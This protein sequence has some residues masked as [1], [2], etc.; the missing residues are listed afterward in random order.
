[1]EREPTLPT[2]DVVVEAVGQETYRYVYD[3]TAHAV[4]LAG[5]VS[6]EEDW[7]TDLGT[8]PDTLGPDGQPVPVL[9]LGSHPTFPGCR[10]AALPIGLLETGAAEERRV[11]VLAVPAADPA[12]AALA[13]DGG[14]PSAVRTALESAIRDTLGLAGSGLPRWGD[15]A[16]AIALVREARRA[17]RLAAATRS[18]AAA[19]QWEVR[20]RRLRRAT[21]GEAERHTEAEYAVYALP[22]RFQEYARDCLLPSERLLCYVQR[23]PV[24]HRGVWGRLRQPAAHAGL[25]AVTD[26]QV[27]LLADA[28]PPGHDLIYWGYIARAAAVERLLDAAV[29]REGQLVWLEIALATSAGPGQFRVEFA[30]E[31]AAQ[32]EEVA[33]LLRR[34]SPAVNA[35]RPMRRYPV[36]PRHEPASVEAFLDADTVAGLEGQLD[37]RLEPGEVVL[38]RAIAPAPTT[39]A[40]TQLIAVTPRR[41]VTIAR[42]PGRR[43]VLPAEIPLSAVAAVELRN[44]L[45]APHFRLWLGGTAA[46]APLDVRFPYPVIRPFLTLFL[47]VRQLLATPPGVPTALVVLDDTATASAV[48]TSTTS[49]H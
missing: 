29:R 19:P 4:R 20:D 26:Q 9:L 44:A 27:L 36:T 2:L 46:Q 41:L 35:R 12:R 40:P 47:T 37:E 3:A 7:P 10:V 17:R 16:E 13:T 14:V 8:L 49:I 24:R 30:S 33:A 23:S 45:L 32:A 18:H 38:A 15:T 5:V 1:M 11:W 21:P 25:V 22:Y 34:F 39:D 48:A 42:E 6:P 31:E 28:M 43:G